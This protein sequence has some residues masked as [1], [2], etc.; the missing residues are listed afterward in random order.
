MAET[1]TSRLAS[2]KD[3]PICRM[4]MG[5]GE[6][7]A[8]SGKSR[9]CDPVLDHC[10]GTG[11]EGAPAGWVDPQYVDVP[12]IGPVL[13]HPGTDSELVALVASGNIRMAEHYRAELVAALEVID[14]ALA[15]RE[16]AARPPRRGLFGSRQDQ[17]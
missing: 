16:E 8:G 2:H 13:L 14:K 5:T 6:L 9:T 17:A 12:G 10:T 7:P 3:W 11:R 15:A 4:C 1:S